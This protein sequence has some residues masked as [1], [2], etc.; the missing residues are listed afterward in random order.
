MHTFTVGKRIT[1]GFALIILIA[2]GMGA[3]AV[4]RLLVIR[5]SAHVI[6]AD[7]LPGAYLSGRI[8]TEVTSAEMHV[9][10]HI[11]TEDASALGELEAEITANRDRVTQLYKDYEKTVTLAEDRELLKKANAFRPGYLTRRDAV[12]ALSR[13]AKKKEAAEMA[14]KELEPYFDTY[15]AA[16]QEVVQFNR[17]NAQADSEQITTAVRTMQLAIG[18][19][20]L[21]AVGLG[22]S[23]ATYI[24]RGINRALGEVADAMQES[25]EQVAAAANQVAAS[26][27]SLA[28]GSAEQAAS[29]EETSAS[30]EEMASMTKRNA[31]GA[32]QAKEFSSQ[33][34]VAADSGATNMHA[35]KTAMDE[36]KTSSNDISH[37]I[38]TID[39][40]AFQTNIL[41]LNAAV[42]AARAGEA[43]MGFAVV[44]EEVRSLAQRS[45]QSARETAEKIAVAIAKTNQGV[46]LSNVVAQSLD[47]IVEKSRKVDAFVAE[48][49]TAST[50]QNQGIGQVN[51][52]V[53]QMD[54]VTQSNAGG[55]E[56][57]AAAAEELSAQ[58]KVTRENVER[59]L[60]LVGRRDGKAN[61]RM[62][63]AL[64]ITAPASG[65]S[66]QRMNGA[67]VSAPTAHPPR[68]AANHALAEHGSNG[69][70]RRRAPVR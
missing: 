24:V 17:R 52:A 36:I 44:A 46:Q 69:G 42:E 70:A 43:G 45:A 2:V 47:E 29:L 26:S 50:E 67:R 61:R 59:L 30:L 28:S 7:C 57:T 10:K 32:Q 6:V 65:V 8:E 64:V 54:K 25:S 19:A 51:S 38:K 35:M 3:L 15:M 39:E 66:E 20:V 33:A 31:E 49:A 41:A 40:I 12:L 34:R 53:G 21:I 5:D 9:R 63:A 1:F 13:A 14:A 4:E 48:I 68:S 22:A 27:Q 55:A 18:M 56:E 58:A 23:A 62:D 11:L 60:E 37:I 16:V